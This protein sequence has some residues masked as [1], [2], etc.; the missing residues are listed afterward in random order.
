MNDNMHKVR[1]RQE[2]IRVRQNRVIV[3][4]IQHKHSKI[5][6]E[7]MAFYD[8]LNALYPQ[9]TD[10]R[11]TYEFQAFVT[12]AEVNKYK[13]L[14]MAQRQHVGIT[15]NMV[16]NIQL[17]D[18]STVPAVP[19]AVPPADPLTVPTAV[20]TAVPPAD[21]LTVPTAVPTAVPP[22]DPLTVPT[23]VPTAVPPADPLTV[24]TAVPT[25]VPPADPLTV[26]TAVP[27]AVPPADPLTVPTAV[28]TAVSPADPLTVSAVPTPVSPM[29]IRVEDAEITLPVL[30]DDV[31]DEIIQH[32]R[33]D[34]DIGNI[35]DDIDIN[36]QTPLE[37]EL[38]LW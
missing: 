4:Y 14:G 24:P 25:A 6:Q 19:T 22:A 17:M 9:K 33:L 18:N 15:D 10:L 1:R 20:P 2:A 30:A 37:R 31:I 23:A 3:T 32:L 12:G 13:P 27:T 5:Y 29:D 34:P 26:P 8:K 21:P 16:L 28:P 38:S 36:E 35:F 7:A 11:R